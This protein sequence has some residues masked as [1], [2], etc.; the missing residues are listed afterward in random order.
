MTKDSSM[1]T[2]IIA[3][4]HE[5]NILK[6]MTYANSISDHDLV[7]MIIKTNNRK[8]KPRTIYMRNFA[9][10]NEA[11]YKADL[12]NLDWKNV[13]HESNINKAWD[14]FRS[15]FK[16]VIDKH[17]PLIKKR[18][19]GRDSPW[20]TNEIKMKAHERDYYL[21]ARKSGKGNCTRQI[22]RENINTPRN[23]EIK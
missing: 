22:F 12:C 4:S 21:K 16:S 10:Y 20:F 3:N 9:K 1:L 18:V 11:N 17:A 19:C 15:L 2:D 13:M 6:T 14:I 8:F 5:Q 7:G 23:F